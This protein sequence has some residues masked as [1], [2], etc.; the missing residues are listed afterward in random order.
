MRRILFCALL[1]IMTSAPLL[2]A[3]DSN[4]ALA[5]LTDLIRRGQLPQLI[6][7]AN[8]LLATDKLTPA[9]QHLALIYLGYAYQQR[10]EFTKA[11][12]SYEKALAVV[13]RDGQHPSDYA[14][15]LATLAA[16]YA[17]IGQFDTAKHVLLRSVHMF[18]D[19]GDHAGAA[20]IWND[21]ATVAVEQHSRGEAHKYIARSVAESQLAKDFTTS[22][23]AALATTEGRI[24]ELDGDPRTAISDYQH[25]LDLWKQSHED[26]QPKTAWLYV[27]LG[28]A[29]LQAG[30]VANA[31]ESTSRGLSMLEA[32]SGR[33]TPR[34]FAAE[35]AYSKVLDAS[36]AHE[37]ASR[38]RQDAQ[39]SL[40]TGTDRQRA[41]SQISVNALR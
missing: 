39:A 25:S 10:G 1:G 4:T 30:D 28:S 41:Q 24:A 27:L 2:R 12:S 11:T 38:L 34:Y 5:N 37:E 17:Q 19:Q 20:M 23:L 26:Q 16:V 35:V 7:A 14:A 15:T 33:E 13:N 36:G 9:G 18:E 40:N 3:Q 22:E 32:S 31:R 8:S 6:Q 29:Y 21:L